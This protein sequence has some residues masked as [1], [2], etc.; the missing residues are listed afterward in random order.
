MKKYKS[1]KDLISDLENDLKSIQEIINSLKSPKR[2]NEEKLI[3][4]YLVKRS[5]PKVAE[6]ARNKGIRAPGDLSFQSGHMSNL[7]KTGSDKV[8]PA[9]LEM[10]RSIFNKNSIAVGRAYG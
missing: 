6:F 5:T 4:E 1:K 8:S 10:A 7:I 2:T 3:I 9:L